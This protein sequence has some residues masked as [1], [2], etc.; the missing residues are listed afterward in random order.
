MVCGDNAVPGQGGIEGNLDYVAVTHFT[1]HQGFDIVAERGPERG[2]VAPLFVAARQADLRDAADFAFQDLTM[3]QSS[4]KYLLMALMVISGRSSIIVRS[5]AVV[6][7]AFGCDVKGNFS[8]LEQ[9]H[10]GQ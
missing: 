10:W 3:R 7:L 6:I 5:S 4:W 8:T 9:W 2:G 1:D